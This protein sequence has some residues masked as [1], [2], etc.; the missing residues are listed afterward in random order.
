LRKYDERLEDLLMVCRRCHE[1]IHGHSDY[2]PRESRQRVKE[3]IAMLSKMSEDDQV[4]VL[5]E[6]LQEERRYHG[7]I[8]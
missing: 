4:A 2:D 3:K 5:I 1:F 6:I 8:Q 7:I